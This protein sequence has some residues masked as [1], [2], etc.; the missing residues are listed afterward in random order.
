MTELRAELR[1]RYD[2]PDVIVPVEPGLLRVAAWLP[3]YFVQ[4]V[5]NGERF[6]ADE[7]VQAGWMLLKLR[8]TSEGDLLVQEPG[9]DGV[10]IRWVDGASRCVR[11]LALQRAICDEL[12]VDT[13]FPSLRHA[14]SATEPFP[15]DEGLKM[16]RTEP[17]GAHSGWTIHEGTDAGLRLLSLYGAAL[18]N[19]AIIA[20]LALPVGSIVEREAGVLT[21]SAGGQQS[22]S[23]SSNLLGQLGRQ[24]SSS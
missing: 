9:F 18:A 12:G 4:R 19:P 14:A 24:S 13:N 11:S 23:V 16:I 2:H 3:D 21:V 5:A 6:S 17:A 20:F 8:R 22:T 10:P 15:R 7:T 1:G